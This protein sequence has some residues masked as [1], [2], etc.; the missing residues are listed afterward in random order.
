MM[1]AVYLCGFSAN[2]HADVTL[3]ETT[4]YY[5]IS[6]HSTKE[7][8]KS[9]NKNRNIIAN[10]ISFDASTR[11]SLGWTFNYLP[12]D[13]NCFITDAIVTVK[14]EYRLP[15]W[16]GRDTSENSVLNKSWD[17]YFE[18]LRDH[19]SDHGHIV[20]NAAD[21]INKNL[22]NYHKLKPTANCQKMQDQAHEL[23]KQI[24]EES[25]LQHQTFDTETEHGGK[26]GA[27]FP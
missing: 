15:R 3:E 23:A 9:I 13:T 10:N 16:T 14:I 19:E 4:I 21:T 26:T 11:W 7:L 1:A 24:V 27:V 8:R 20:K 6:G 17:T 5:N 12:A 2:L 18:N 25:R 22:L